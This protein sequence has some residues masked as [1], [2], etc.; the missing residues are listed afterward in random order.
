[1]NVPIFTAMSLLQKLG[2]FVE[3]A[4]DLLEEGIVHAAASIEGQ[5]IQSLVIT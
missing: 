4:P 5:S 3:N 1:M 2:K